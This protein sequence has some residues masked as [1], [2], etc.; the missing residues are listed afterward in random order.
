M[1]TV[2]L[3]GEL[4]EDTPVRCDNCDWTGTSKD[5][6]EWISDIQERIYPGEIVPAGE[7]P[8]CGACAHVVKALDDSIV[9]AKAMRLLH[10]LIADIEAMRD[11]DDPN[12]FGWFSES[13]TDIARGGGTLAKIEWPNLAILTDE[14]K[15]LFEEAKDRQEN[16]N[17]YYAAL[18]DVGDKDRADEQYYGWFAS[19]EEAIER[20]HNAFDGYETPIRLQAIAQIVRWFDVEQPARI[21]PEHSPRKVHVRIHEWRG[22]IEEVDVTTDPATIEK[23]TAE[24]KAREEHVDD[25]I[26]VFEVEPHKVIKGDQR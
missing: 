17:I 25:Q 14:A 20:W 22:L 24:A 6:N 12:W 9:E 3:N 7:C 13:E 19:V 8:E 15:A 18:Y 1:T 5:L 2:C 4:P 16:P 11:E 23:W 10:S 21:P 26:Y